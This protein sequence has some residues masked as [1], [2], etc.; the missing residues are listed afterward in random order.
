MT[1]LNMPATFKEG[2]RVVYIKDPYGIRPV[3][4][5]GTCKKPQA[6]HGWYVEWDNNPGKW[7]TW[8]SNSFL[9]LLND[10]AEYESDFN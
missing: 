8:S 9:A 5:T 3:G 1:T 10:D 4:T 2:D 6:D 7:G